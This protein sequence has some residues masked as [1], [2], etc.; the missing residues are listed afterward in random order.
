MKSQ[1]TIFLEI[2]IVAIVLGSVFTIAYTNDQIATKNSVITNLE[3]KTSSLNE[4]LAQDISAISFNEQ[5]IAELKANQSIILGNESALEAQISE[6][7]NTVSLNESTVLQSNNSTV[8]K[9]NETVDNGSI[10]NPTTPQNST[11]VPVESMPYAGYLNITLV[12]NATYAYISVSQSSSQIMRFI[13]SNSNVVACGIGPCY[14]ATLTNVIIPIS[15]P[16]NTPQK[17]NI[18]FLFYNVGARNTTAVQLSYTMT[19]VY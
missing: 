1:L 11:N 12:S 17:L 9:L 8:I 2:A 14:N 3:S 19:Y 13:A 5:E 16:F 4:T 6:L 7:L 10:T 15:P 18:V